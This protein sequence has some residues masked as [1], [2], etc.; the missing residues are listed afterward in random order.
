M[1]NG[2][3]DNVNAGVVEPAMSKV[4]S[5][6][7]ATE[8]AISVL[9][10][11]DYIKITVRDYYVL[12]TLFFWIFATTAIHYSI[13]RSLYLLFSVTICIVF[14]HVDMQPNQEGGGND[15][16]SAVQSGAIQG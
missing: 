3:R 10:I 5:I 1:G 12:R 13:Y 2:V 16:H 6:K 14:S 11:D 9:R 4:K 8:A 7:F 15:Y